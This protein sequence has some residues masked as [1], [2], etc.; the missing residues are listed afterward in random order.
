MPAEYQR[1]LPNLV[2]LRFSE[3][4]SSGKLL[5]STMRHVQFGR[6][7]G[8]RIRDGEPV[9]NP[10]PKLVRVAKIGFSG[11]PKVPEA[12][13][14]VLKSAVREL[15]R[16]FAALQNGTIDR[17]VFHRGLPCLVEISISATATAPNGSSE[18]GVE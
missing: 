8:I 7:E 2:A 16:E 18:R 13:D 14:W 5:V 11:D 17:V 10:P 1:S 15:F 12:S 6:F 3:L 4:S 9:W